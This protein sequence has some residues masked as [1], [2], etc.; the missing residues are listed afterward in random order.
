MLK[1]VTYFY[2]AGSIYYN[3]DELNSILISNG[4][5]FNVKEIK[6][7]KFE[8]IGHSNYIKLIEIGKLL[9]MLE[10]RYY[11]VIYILYN[12]AMNIWKIG[13]T[14]N[15][16][17]RIEQINTSIPIKKYQYKLMGSFTSRNL[18]K[19]ETTIHCKLRTVFKKYKREFYKIKTNKR[20]EL[21]SIIQQNIT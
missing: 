6:K 12:S 15:I 18:I 3:F 8:S 16:K 21:F 13:K 20:K 1:S 17:R 19:D 14:R 2:K 5:N 11:G 7:I 9:H 4:Y 10:K